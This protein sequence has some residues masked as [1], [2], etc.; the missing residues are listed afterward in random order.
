M[1]DLEQA[2]RDILN[3]LFH[4]TLATVRA[5]RL[6]EAALTGN[7]FTH[8]IALGK[9]GEAL[10]AGAW[11]AATSPSFPRKRESSLEAGFLAFPR[12]YAT[13]DLPDEALFERRIGAHPL[14]DET[15]LEA[16]TALLRFVDALPDNA[17]VAVLLSGGASVSVEVPAPGVD[18]A[19]LQRAN[20]WLLASGLPI[21]D[22]NRV[23]ARLS[24]LKGGGLVRRLARVHPCV[25]ILSDVGDSALE[26]VGGGLC[27]P[28]PSGPMPFVPDWLQERLAPLPTDNAPHLLL[29]RLAGNAEA[30]AAVAGQGATIVGS[31]DGEA[32]EAGRRIGHELC[33]REPGLYVWGGEA[34]VRLPEAPGQGGRCQ[35]LALAAALEIAGRNDCFL[36]AAST[37]GWDGTEPVAGACVDG[38]TT[39]RGTAHGFDARAALGKANA[40]A[41]LEASGDLL[42]TGPTGT[43]VNDLVIALKR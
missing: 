27:A 21:K 12:G 43:H 9:A 42:R 36:L 34:T 41:F 11:R 7:D 10:A 1:K 38:G 13:G 32:A 16:G 33:R 25:W 4:R 37:D 2:P 40:G 19:L 8:V 18:L 5:D 26:W 23:R 14:P 30:V 3:A 28:L 24:Q 22:I 35:Q 20:R 6:A 39:S 29:E 17:R 15:S 31:L